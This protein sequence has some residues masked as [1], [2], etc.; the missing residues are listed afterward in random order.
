MHFIGLC[1][2]YF[3]RLYTNYILILKCQP[4]FIYFIGLCSIDL[5]HPSKSI[6]IYKN[7]RFLISIHLIYWDMY[8]KF[9]LNEC[10][11]IFTGLCSI[12]FFYPSP[13]KFIKIIGFS[14]TTTNMVVA[15]FY[16][17]Y[18]FMVDRSFPSIKVT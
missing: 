2:I 16:S 15:N 13:S 8:M 7:H 11:Y 1:S 12:E 4:I 5:F 6:K 9:P 3:F 10:K 14:S 17:F 18:R